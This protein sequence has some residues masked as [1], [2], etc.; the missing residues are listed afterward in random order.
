MPVRKTVR[1]S[2]ADDETLRRLYRSY[3]IPIDQY[4]GRPVERARLTDA[5]N[6]ATGQQLGAET[7]LHYMIRRRKDGKWE[8]F[9]GDHRRAK[10]VPA[11]LFSDEEWRIVDRLY[12]DFG[13]GADTFIYK[14]KVATK[15]AV[16]V[17]AAL[18][19]AVRP[20]VL[21]AALVDRRKAD[22]LP[23]LGPD[24]GFEDIDEVA[25]A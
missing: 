6:A 19:R 21:A 25:S 8:T 11:D 24:A 4:R 17:S 14:S 1:L 16:K 9:D 22:A 7:L 13:V 10:P 5:F 20:D 3:R 18:G 12:V 23:R 15:F 2:P